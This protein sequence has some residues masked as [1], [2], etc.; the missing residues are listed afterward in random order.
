M[1]KNI[2]NTVLENSDKYIRTVLFLV[3][4][5]HGLVS[6]GFSPSQALHFKLIES[7]NFSLYPS[8]YFL[9][10]FGWLDIIVS[11]LFIFK[12]THKF[13]AKI[14]LVYLILVCMAVINFYNIKTGSYLGIAEI[15]RRFSWISLILFLIL[16]N[17]GGEK[18]Y[19]IRISSASAFIAHGFAS[20]GFFGFNQAHIE[21]AS[22]IIPDVY[23]ND[24]IFYSGFSDLLIGFILLIGFK[25]KLFA[26]I[27]SCW[28]FMIVILSSIISIPDGIFRLGFLLVCIYNYIDDRTNYPNLYSLIKNKYGK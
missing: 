22:Q 8:R 17:D 28:I 12:S 19:L 11:F 23:V 27:G 5:G 21:I 15:L 6:L 18:F 20:L 7:I 26:L 3:F 9:L 2:N 24:F 13:A 4:F 14:G 16:K 1:L 10:C 25:K